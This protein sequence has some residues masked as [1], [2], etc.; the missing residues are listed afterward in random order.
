MK[1]KLV[2]GHPL[3][4]RCYFYWPQEKVMFSQMSVCAQGRSP[5][6]EGD[7]HSGGRPASEG[8]P[9]WR[10]TPRRNKGTDRKWHHTP[11][12]YWHLVAA[13]AAVGTYPAGMHSCDNDTHD[14]GDVCRFVHLQVLTAIC[15]ITVFALSLFIYW[16]ILLSWKPLHC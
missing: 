16:L 12:G 3:C 7:L 11:P 8:D 4:E 2:L 10:E 5:P 6:L 9:L 1:H 14:I 15:S 13:T